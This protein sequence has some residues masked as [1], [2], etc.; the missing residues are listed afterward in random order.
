MV[1]TALISASYGLQVQTADPYLL[2]NVKA[3]LATEYGDLD[4]HTLYYAT[5]VGGV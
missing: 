5:G 1:G 3:F 4:L 2:I